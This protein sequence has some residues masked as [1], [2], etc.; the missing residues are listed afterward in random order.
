MLV[1]RRVTPSIKFAG[2]HLY[3]W[4][5][6]GTVRVK[7]L[8][9]EHNTMSPA[10][11][12]TRTTRSGVERTNHEAPAPLKLYKSKGNLIFSFLSHP[13]RSCSHKATRGTH[14]G[15]ACI[16]CVKQATTETHKQTGMSVLQDPTPGR[17]KTWLCLPLRS[18]IKCLSTS[19]C[20][21]CIHQ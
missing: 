17:Y 18:D 1:H 12:R 6:R 2:T 21:L 13:E 20:M 15:I 8:A 5:E 9:Q 7:C 3:T 10:R 19:L 16:G 4:V 14:P 11:P